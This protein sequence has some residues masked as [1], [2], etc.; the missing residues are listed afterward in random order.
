MKNTESLKRHISHLADSHALLE[1]KLMSLELTHQ[2]D[3]R[4]AADIKKKKLY[5]KDEIQRCNVELDLLQA[6]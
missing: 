4:Q 5:I 1:K 2:N 6:V 3:T